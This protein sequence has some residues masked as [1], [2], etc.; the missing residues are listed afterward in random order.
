MVTKVTPDR[1]YHLVHYGGN[2]GQGDGAEVRRTI[3]EGTAC[4]YAA[5]QK[6]PT[7]KS[8][9]NAGS[10]SEYGAK[11]DAMRE[12]MLPEPNIEYGI[13][14][15]WATLYGEYLRREKGMPIT[16]LRIFSAYG[17]YEAGA[18]LFPG[19]TMSLMEGKSPKLS[20][21][22]SVRDFIYVDDIVRA[23]ITATEKPH[24]VYNIGTGVQSSLR[25]VVK[26]LCSELGSTIELTWGL[27]PEGNLK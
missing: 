2:R 1:V 26:L 20:D 3:I 27:T 18:R 15:L 4:L 8:I 14:K 13:A 25:E 23:F 9:V 24:G 17:P 12:D 22:N 5:C 7:I 19:V 16:T 10:S 11:K 6:V 21:P